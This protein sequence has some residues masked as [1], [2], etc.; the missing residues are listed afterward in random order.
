MAPNKLKKEFEKKRK[1]NIKQ[2]NF[3]NWN[4]GYKLL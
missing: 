1:K 3:C 4:C 2:H